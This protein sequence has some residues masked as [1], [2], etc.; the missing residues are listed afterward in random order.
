MDKENV[1][2]RRAKSSNAIASRTEG[3]SRRTA[4]SWPKYRFQ[5][6]RPADRIHNSKSGRLRGGRPVFACNLNIKHGSCVEAR[7][8]LVCD[9]RA[10][11]SF[12]TPTELIR[13]CMPL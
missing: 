2:D 1:S 6:A 11:A 12:P 9:S 5:S 8:V 7:V 10:G 3:D 4:E 13:V